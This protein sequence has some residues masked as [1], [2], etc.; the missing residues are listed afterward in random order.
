MKNLYD[1]LKLNNKDASLEEIKKSYYKLAEIHHPDKNNGKESQEFID[2]T[3]AYTILKDRSKRDEYDQTGKFDTQI[4]TVRQLALQGLASLF[5]SM[6]KNPH[7]YFQRNDLF[8]QMQRELESN[9]GKMQSKDRAVSLSIERLELINDRISGKD[10]MFN[11]MLASDLNLQKVTRANI[12]KEK[13]VLKEAQ[14]II[15]DYKYKVD[16][17]EFISFLNDDISSTTSTTGG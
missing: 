4:S 8:V 9:L 12:E 5:L 15:K 3:T 14:E 7:W 2:I 10:A 13:K 1:I 6:I 17:Q 11:D 16:Q